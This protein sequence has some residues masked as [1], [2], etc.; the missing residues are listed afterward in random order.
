MRPGD[1]LIVVPDIRLERL[2]RSPVWAPTLPS[3]SIKPVS[4][5]AAVVGRAGF[6]GGGDINNTITLNA[7]SALSAEGRPS[8]FGSAMTAFAYTHRREDKAARFYQ[9]G[10]LAAG[11]R[12]GIG[13]NTLEG[14]PPT[15]AGLS[16][17]LWS[18]GR[19]TGD[20]SGIGGGGGGGGGA[21]TMTTA[22]H[23]NNDE[24]DQSRL[25]GLV[26]GT[27]HLTSRYADHFAAPSPPALA[28]FE[29]KG[30][31][32]VTVK[33]AVAPTSDFGV[34][35]ATRQRSG[36]SV[37]PGGVESDV[38]VA[39]SAVA[40]ALLEP[41]RPVGRLSCTLVQL[42]TRYACADER[43]VLIVHKRVPHSLAS[44]FKYVVVGRYTHLGESYLRVVQSAANTIWRIHTYINTYASDLSFRCDVGKARG[45]L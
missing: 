34:T 8:T 4:A 23:G 29:E 27:C 20:G 33:T 11:G 7:F 9:P 31:A 39:A 32:G 19:G 42:S 24:G 12:D 44:S 35:L 38:S 2:R 26:G 30:G 10:R 5:P 43:R 21:L 14:G 17:R 40:P 45:W 18:E 22:N 15:A 41:D 16:F 36:G 3:R 13:T 6:T 25:G 28:S 37:G 1:D